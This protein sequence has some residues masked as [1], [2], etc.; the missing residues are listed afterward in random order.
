M[1][2][3]ARRRASYEDVLQA[4][5]NMIAEV[6]YGALHTQPRPAFRHANA[7]S[8]LGI[9]LG[10]PFRFGKGG[11]GGWVIL[12]EP[13]LHLGDDILVPDIAG[14]RR[15]R[16]AE[17]PED[18]PWTTIVPDWICEVLSPSTQ[19]LDR[20]DKMEIYLRER[21][22]H[23][24]LVDPIVRTLEIYR[25]AETVWQRVAVFRDDALV[26]GEPFDAFELELGLLWER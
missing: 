19:A 12:D 10:A 18:A 24:W 2:A 17:L 8:H 25:F 26:R 15:E 7:S 1:T 14:W 13:E 9:L 23:A 16:L 21:V 3:P 22:G 11:P 6:I 4:P 20:A 5:P